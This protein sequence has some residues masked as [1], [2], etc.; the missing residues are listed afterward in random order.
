MGFEPERIIPN[1]LESL[2][3]VAASPVAAISPPLESI[4]GLQ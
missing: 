2:K 3:P 1:G 4:N